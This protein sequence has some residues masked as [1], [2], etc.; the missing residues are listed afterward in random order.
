MKRYI[1]VNSSVDSDITRYKKSLER[2]V[3]KSGLYENFGQDE[4]RK[5]R[6]KYRELPDDTTDYRTAE[7]NRNSISSFE[8]WCVN[9]VGACGDV[10]GSTKYGAD[11]CSIGA[12]IDSD[13]KYYEIEFADVNDESDLDPDADDSQFICILGKRKPSIKEAE[14]FCAEDMKLLGSN[15]IVN[16]SELTPEEAH[17]FYD[18][19]NEDSYPIFE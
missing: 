15:T 8:D 13:I 18:M 6:A 12:S 1:K 11:M 5:L 3:A 7:R 4:I 14:E 16:I 2:K 9:Y 10:T 19:S 17:A